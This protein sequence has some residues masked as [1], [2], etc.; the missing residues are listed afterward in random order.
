MIYG[1]ASGLA[2]LHEQRVIHGNLRAT[3]VL[4]NP[5]I[6]PAICSFGL[7][8]F[9]TNVTSTAM[10]GAGALRWMAPETLEGAPRATSTDVYAFAMTITEILTGGLPFPDISNTVGVIRA[11]LLGKR[12]PFDPK[13][14][15][16][17]KFDALWDIAASCWQEDPDQRPAI[18]TILESLYS[19]TTEPVKLCL[20]CGVRPRFQ[21]RVFCGRTCAWEAAV[22]G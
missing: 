8:K 15:Q 13:G 18:Q 6:Q 16:G 19:P 22:D 11:I 2:Y 3:A 9:D 12:P 10:Q 21:G 5:L 1:I 14:R 4:L 20:H 7:A 17:K